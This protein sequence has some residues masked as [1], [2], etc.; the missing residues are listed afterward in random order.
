MMT[1]PSADELL[2]NVENRFELVSVVSKRAR[3][4]VDGKAPLVN[5]NDKSEVTIASLELFKDKYSKLENN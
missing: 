2:K 4:I 5:T 3:Q 1:K